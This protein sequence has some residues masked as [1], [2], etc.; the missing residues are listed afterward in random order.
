VSKETVLQMVGIDKRFYG[1]HALKEFSFECRKGEVHVLMGENGAGK[2]TLL[3]ILSGIYQA[4]S[5]SILLNGEQVT[6]KNPIDAKARGIAIIHQEL[7][8]CKNMT[9]AENIFRGEEYTKP[10]FGFVDYKSMYKDAQA[11]LDKMNMDLRSDRLVKT[12]SVA[13]QQMVEIAGA[14]SRNAQIVIMD[15]PTASLTNKEISALFKTI[16]Q[17]RED[18]VCI[19]YV[20]HRM[21]E[22]FEIGDRVTVMR[23]GNYIGTR[24]VAD[25]TANELVEMMVGRPIGAQYKGSKP[26]GGEVVLEAIDL[27]NKKLKNVSFDLRK[28]EILGFSG[29]VGAGRTETARA[30]FGLDKLDSGEIRLE[31]EPV[32]IKSPHEAIKHGIGLI[33]ED[34]KGA[35]LILR[36]PVGFNLTITVVDRFI[37]GIRVNRK[38]EYSIIDRYKDALSIKM[39]GPEQAA[40]N[41]SGGNQ[42][43]VVISKWL[44]TEPKYLIMDEPTRGIDVGAKNEIYQLMEKLAS[45]GLSIIFISSDLPEIVNMSSRVVIMR[46]GEI[47]GIMDSNEEEITQVAIMQQA[48]GGY[49]K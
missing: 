49:K 1:V 44:A 8:M 16:H 39:V 38:K 12:L 45:E 40:M 13:Q 27:N 23:D 6:I 18:N 28:G 43:K 25:S 4:D 34:R 17:L 33:P 7:S 20:S 15:E 47:A 35:G 31:G 37:K 11:M 3:K 22:T 32:K 46:E 19:I 48:T 2:S 14:L 21:N 42:Q 10:P 36:K 26:K 5:G 41:L 24:E 9:I 30:L 29:L